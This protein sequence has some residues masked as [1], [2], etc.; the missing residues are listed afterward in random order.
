MAIGMGSVGYN[1]GGYHHH[2]HQY[3]QEKVSVSFIFTVI[4]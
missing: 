4:N 2:Q 3:Q 1:C